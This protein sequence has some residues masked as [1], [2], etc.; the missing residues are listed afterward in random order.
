LIPRSRPAGNYD[1]GG[2]VDVNN[3]VNELDESN[4]ARA[5]GIALPITADLIVSTVQVLGVRSDGRVDYSVTVCNEG[6]IRA[7]TVLVSLYASPN[8]LITASDPYVER[9]VAA[10]PLDVDAC[11]TIATV[12][13][14]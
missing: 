3:G 4:N 10:P 1:F 2:I 13:S 7:D 9:G 5:F 14:P 6:T 8:T 12:P 11:S